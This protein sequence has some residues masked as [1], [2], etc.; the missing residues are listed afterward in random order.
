MSIL[1]LFCL[2][3]KKVIVTG[4]A[5]GI[6]F[7]IGLALA[8]AG[9][10]VAIIDINEEGAKI[11]AQKIKDST[12]RNCIA[13][14]ADVTNSEEVN[15]MIKEVL[16]TFGEIDIA[17]CNAGIVRN[18]PVE[19]MSLNQWNK[20]ISVNLTGVFLTT[21]ASGLHMI[22]RNHGGSII[23]IGSI[24]GYIIPCPYPQCS[25]NAS[26]AA[27]IQLVKS[28]AVEWGGGGGYEH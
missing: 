22:N 10:H 11:A 3:T 13:V 15:L 26:K 4:G 6:G 27:V 1:D 16:T 18:I 20:V 14:K 21:Q 7:S 8:E 12:G 9:A 2:N 23:V 24:A 17:V 25:Y 19:K 5:N 28:L